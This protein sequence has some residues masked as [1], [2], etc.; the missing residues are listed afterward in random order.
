MSKNNHP[1]SEAPPP[2]LDGLCDEVRV[3]RR[4]VS[5]A[6][7]A[8]S[9]V[10]AAVAQER[11]AVVVAPPSK[12]VLGP[13]DRDLV[14][15]KPKLIRVR[16]PD[17]ML[18]LDIQL[19]NLRVGPSGL[20]R[21]QAGQPA[22][23]IVDHQPQAIAD[24]AYQETN[25]PKIN[26]NRDG[27]AEPQPQ[28]K[29]KSPT[30]P[31]VADARIA[32]P[33]RVVFAMPAGQTGFAFGDNSV[34]EGLLD[35]CRTWP[36]V[37]EDTAAPAPPEGVYQ[38]GQAAHALGVMHARLNHA[39]A[40]LKAGLPARQ[41]AAL[42]LAIDA[43]A[44]E[45]GPAI[46]SGVQVGLPLSEPEIDFMIGEALAKG[47]GPSRWRRTSA[48][49]LLYARR[50]VEA[51][52]ACDALQLAQAATNET[53]PGVAPL[54]RTRRPIRPLPSAAPAP[55]VTAPMTRAPVGA[56]RPPFRL[57]PFR[58]VPTP[59]PQQ[60]APTPVHPVPPE[61]RSPTVVRPLPHQVPSPHAPSEQVTA[62]E[63]PYRL[64][65]SPLESAGWTHATAP[66]KHRG[67]TELWHTR[68][69][70][71]RPW[72]VDDHAAEPLRAIWSWDYPDNAPHDFQ[73]PYWALNGADRRML[74]KLTA[75]FGEKIGAS[76]PMLMAPRADYTPKPSTAKR[77]MLS[78]LGGWLDL[79]G[80]WN[81][82]PVNVDIEA[83]SHKT[84]MARDYFVRVVYAGF[85]FPFGHAAS[86][87]KVTERKFE[88]QGDGGRAAVLRQRFFIIVR[89]PVRAYPG[90]GQAFGGRDF[91]F[92]SV[93]ILTKV[94]ADLAFPGANPDDRMPEA[95]YKPPNDGQDY[96]RTAFFP[97]SAS[98][99]FLF[100]MAG[101]DGA[102][103]RIPFQAPLL[104]V[105]ELHNNPADIDQIAGVYAASK[106]GGKLRSQVAMGG[107]VIQYAPQTIGTDDKGDTNIPTDW[108]MLRG[109]RTQ[110]SLDAHAAQFYPGFAKAQTPLP[111]IKHLLQSDQSPTVSFSKPYLDNGFAAGP[112]QVFLDIQSPVSVPTDSS[113][114]TDKFGGL[115]SPNLAP[116]A[117]SRNFGL[118]SGAAAGGGNAAKFLSGQFDPADYLPGDAKLLGFIPLK[119][120]LRVIDVAASPTA[121]PKLSNLDLPDRLEVGFSLRQGQLKS[122]SDLFVPSDASVLAIDAKTIVW[123]N[124]NPAQSSVDGAL[125][126]FKVNLFGFIILAFDNLSF[127][128]EPGK[129]SDVSVDLNPDHGVMFGGPL[130]FVNTLKDFIPGN[131]FADPP[132]I[133]VTPAGVS[134]SYSL[135]LP[136]ISVGALSLQNISFGAGF[137]LPFTGDAPSVRFNFAERHNP[138]NLTVS[139]YGGGGFVA[140]TVDTGGVRE[141]E[142]SL[143]F[144]AQI[145]IDLGVAS[146]GV[147]IKGGFYFHWKD[148]PDQLVYLEGYVELGG[149]LTVLGLITA[150]LVFHLGLAYEKAGTATRLF[151]Q[152]TLTVEVDVMFFSTSVDV[153]VEKQF[154][155]S[156]DPHFIDL[157][158]DAET[159]GAY[160]A[161]FA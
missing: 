123:R 53:I 140:I 30:P 147:Y 42:V 73:P 5:G 21:L 3:T 139:L 144:G 118:V 28:A 40:A 83:W 95:F 130:E 97:I 44:A 86:L 6:L 138:F 125:N 23:L 25:G 112:G 159:W 62:L 136:T 18:I 39:E 10:G 35:A 124:G 48:E 155:G 154:A 145:A 107:A 127:H 14:L 69:G 135:G 1:D 84:A 157:I 141:L 156:S 33:S 134:A 72:G 68:L 88:T 131:G 160:C 49:T 38:M 13:L 74:V 16:R 92:Q 114:P 41:R 2:D 158:P 7:A 148:H 126:D 93:E 8:L 71:R 61:T 113:H 81:V 47:L 43:A 17:D 66:V 9:A 70:A 55:T 94:T 4:L 151:G 78:A 65:Q 58:P 91:P 79:D 85:L 115:I 99:D 27:V 29:D 57:P 22:L 82:R 106:S 20:T 59:A 104:F 60:T 32:G 45:A 90:P 109:G 98:G 111:T 80:N 146:G 77:L 122:P 149:H 153:M 12:R 37:L 142:A 11:R 133:S 150:S 46:M 137:N 24:Q 56:A 36:M 34:L 120:V 105:S 119:D 108:V 31:D 50:A 54:P 15:N 89:E 67:L 26:V 64:F 51:A 121:T 19:E 96:W 143:E 87:V 52:A 117:L 63:I 152:A 76:G 75:G 116:T 132:G 110:S 103:R 101:V 102:G 161:A 129:K 100:Q 128:A